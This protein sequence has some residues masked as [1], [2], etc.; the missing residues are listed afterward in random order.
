MYVVYGLEDPRDHLYHYIGITDDVYRRFCDHIRGNAGNIEKNGWIFEC[1]QAN[2]MI[3][4][5]E[6]E[7]IAPETDA[8]QRE[9]FWIRYYV[10]LGHPLHNMKLAQAIVGEKTRL[11]K[12]ALQLEAEC[13]LLAEQCQR[14]AEEKA[15]LEEKR[16]S[17]PGT[18]GN[19]IR[20]T[21]RRLNSRG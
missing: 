4:M 17:S 1:R 8:A 21:I 10:H 2:V 16:R 12:Q 20:E 15:H 6:I 19:D 11:E 7:R 14:L 9:K 13:L 18:I 3:I 5:R